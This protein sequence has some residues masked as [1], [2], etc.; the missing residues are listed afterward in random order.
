MRFRFKMSLGL[1]AVAIALWLT[2]S[3][4]AARH[5]RTLAAA[6]EPAVCVVLQK[7]LPLIYPAPDW[8]PFFQKHYYRFG[9]TPTCIW[10]EAQSMSTAQVV[11]SVRY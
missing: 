1:S 11:I 3:P 2:G 4:A 7:P 9:P 5:L 8:R 6:N 10:S